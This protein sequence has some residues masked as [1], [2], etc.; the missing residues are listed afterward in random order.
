[1]SLEQEGFYMSLRSEEITL[2]PCRIY[3]LFKRLNQLFDVVAKVVPLDPRLRVVANKVGSN[4]RAQGQPGVTPI[5]KRKRAPST[6]SVLKLSLSAH[7]D[8][9]TSETTAS[10]SIQTRQHCIDSSSSMPDPS[11]VVTVNAP[12]TLIY[13]TIKLPQILSSPLPAVIIPKTGNN[14]SHGCECTL[15]PSSRRV[16]S[17]QVGQLAI[18]PSSAILIEFNASCTQPQPLAQAPVPALA[19]ALGLAPTT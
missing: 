4:D 12:P 19:L 11:A 10:E 3:C 13:A 17:A 2:A 1:M 6:A 18:S 8:S 7:P 9:S 16:R 14:R 5:A 15:V